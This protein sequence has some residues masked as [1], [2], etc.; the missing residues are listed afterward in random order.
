MTVVFGPVRPVDLKRATQLVNKTNQFNTTTR[1]YNDDEMR[2]LTEDPSGLT[3]QFR[4]LDRFGDNGLVSV[5]LLKP[6]EGKRDA[7]EIDTWV[8]SCRV[9]GRGLENEAMT[10]AVE[11]ARRR[12]I[13]E[14]RADFI[15]TKRNG[16]VAGLFLS[17]GF[18]EVDNACRNGER[19]S[20]R[21]D[22]DEYRPARTFMIRQAQ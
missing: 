16:V 8:M 17:L 4:L 10:I 1:R 15:P 19:S 7:L 20:W 18:T 5:M 22:L 3:L 21:L 12:G 6:V 11:A 9:F 13:H 14:L 2:K